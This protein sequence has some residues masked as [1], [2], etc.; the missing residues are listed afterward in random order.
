MF[1]ALL[2]I[3]NFFF[4]LGMKIKLNWLFGVEHIYCFQFPGY[5]SI[6]PPLNY[7]FVSVMHVGGVG[8]RI[9]LILVWFFT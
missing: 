8:L 4:L 7:Y 3:D 5:K 6:H 9:F 2:S 1:L